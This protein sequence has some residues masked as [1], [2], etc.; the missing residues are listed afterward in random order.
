MM[1]VILGGRPLPEHRIAALIGAGIDEFV[2]RVLEE[3]VRRVAARCGAPVDGLTFC[4]GISTGSALFERSRVYPGVVKTLQALENAAL[5][6]CCI[7]NKESKFALPLL[8]FGRAARTLC[9]HAVRRPSGGSEAESRH[10]ARR[11]RSR[12]V[13]SPRNCCASA[14][15][16]RTSRRLTQ[17]VAAS[18][19]S[20]TAMRPR[21]AAGGLRPDG[22]RQQS[23][24]ISSIAPAAEA[25]DA[26]P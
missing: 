11:L 20:T 19:R 18:S 9:G 1:L 25:C 4:F 6:L 8:E 2:A 13:S 24:K 26:P 12:S 3:S 5:P 10:A 7:T 21:P 15:R 22:H 14:I 16:V 23:S 17:R